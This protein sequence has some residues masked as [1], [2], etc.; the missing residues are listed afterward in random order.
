M[1]K[2]QQR[3]TGQLFHGLVTEGLGGCCVLRVV[4]FDVSEEGVSFLRHNGE[5]IDVLPFSSM[6]VHKA[7]CGRKG[8][9]FQG[10]E[11]FPILY[12]KN[13]AGVEAI[14]ARAPARV[15]QQ[16]SV[17]MREPRSVKDSLRIAAGGIVMVVTMLWAIPSI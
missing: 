2:K 11:Q 16:I 14:R 5:G 7:A 15:H 4:D 3:A 8:T 9:A 1:S 13:F 17:L 10:S 6:R 12:V